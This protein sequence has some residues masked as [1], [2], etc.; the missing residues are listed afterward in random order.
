[1]SET[2]VRSAAEVDGVLSIDFTSGSFATLTP[3]ALETIRLGIL[4]LRYEYV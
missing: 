2:R 1:V 3:A 4:T